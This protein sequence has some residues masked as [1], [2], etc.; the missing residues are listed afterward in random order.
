M[1]AVE[2]V[3]QQGGSLKDL[4][5]RVLRHM[6]ADGLAFVWGWKVSNAGPFL[7]E[8]GEEIGNPGCGTFHGKV[9][10]IPWFE[11]VLQVA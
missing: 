6:G 4:T 8:G 10:H 7:A 1:L 2:V 9:V 3:Y 11:S 5:Y